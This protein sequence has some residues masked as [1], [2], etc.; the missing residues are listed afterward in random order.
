MPSGSNK[1]PACQHRERQEWMTGE[2]KRNSGSID[3]LDLVAAGESQGFTKGEAVM[4][5]IDDAPK[6]WDV[7]LA[8]GTVA[9]RSLE[10]EQH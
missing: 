7:N 9:L 3:F 1:A 5:V 4:A 10:I 8:T 2:I 6:N